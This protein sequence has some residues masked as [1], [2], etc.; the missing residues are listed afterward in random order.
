MRRFFLFSSFVFIL[1]FVHGLYLSLYSPQI[2]PENTIGNN[3]HMF[4]D[5]KGVNHVISNHT[6]GS[7]E[8][9]DILLHA[10]KAKLNFIFFTDLNLL[11][12]PYNIQGYHGNIFVFTS[13]KMSYLDSHLLIYPED[14]NF[15][16][17][18]LSTAHAKLKE[19]FSR[20]YPEA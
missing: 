14:P 4:Y 1:F 17:K 15:Y 10:I 3:H 6:L 20:N 11:D 13:Q 9:K 7:L 2:F 16:F 5:Y 18:S 19:H 8:P 12:R